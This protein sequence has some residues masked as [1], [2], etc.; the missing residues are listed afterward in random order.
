MCLS[1]LIQQL[2]V[3]LKLCCNFQVFIQHFRPGSVIA[4]FTIYYEEV[5][6]NEV[7]QLQELIDET[8]FLGTMPVRAFTIKSPEGKVNH[9]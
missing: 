8:S 9:T 4:N 3:T 2:L 1:K 5:K 6:G 7:L